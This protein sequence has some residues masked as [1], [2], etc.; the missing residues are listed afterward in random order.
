MNFFFALNLGCCCAVHALAGWW[1]RF[2]ATM[3]KPITMKTNNQNQNAQNVRA[4]AHAS[5][6]GGRRPENKDNLDSRANEE[7][8]FKGNDVTHNRK[9]VKSAHKKH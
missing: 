1:Y 9:D 6:S 2:L 5:Q 4:N 8:D 7:Q 3:A